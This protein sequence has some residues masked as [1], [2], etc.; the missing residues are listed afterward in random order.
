MRT[1]TV[2]AV[3][4]LAASSAVAAEAP[5]PMPMISIEGDKF[6]A[7]GKE[8]KIW[9]FNIGYGLH[10]SDRM[11]QKQADQL[12]F[13]GVNLLR[14]HTIDWTQWG[15]TGPNGEELSAGLLPLG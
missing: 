11:L 14:I 8:F 3:L 12:E 10:L 9:G 15:E 13:L 5:R 7:D 2:A 4:L 1:R 6:V